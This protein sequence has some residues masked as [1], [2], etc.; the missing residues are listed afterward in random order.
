[1]RWGFQR[2]EDLGNYNCK[3]RVHANCSMSYCYM[4]FQDYF[5]VCCDYV[6]YYYYYF[7]RD[8]YFLGMQRLLSRAAILFIWNNNATHFPKLYFYNCNKT[9]FSVVLLHQLAIFFILYGVHCWFY[10]VY[11]CVLTLPPALTVFIPV[12]VSNQHNIVY[13]FELE[14]FYELCLDKRFVLANNSL[15]YF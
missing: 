15:F 4:C 1:M 7:L 8:V 13:I 12:N 11:L 9:F 2:E 10:F 14:M 5:C 3:T 6:H